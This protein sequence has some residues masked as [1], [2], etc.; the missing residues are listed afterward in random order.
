MSSLTF[1]YFPFFLC[2][3]HFFLLPFLWCLCSFVSYHIANLKKCCVSILVIGYLNLCQACTNEGIIG[4]KI[5]FNK[6]D[7]EYTLITEGL[8]LYTYTITWT[9]NSG[10]TL[11]RIHLNEKKKKKKRGGGNENFCRIILVVL[12][13][14]GIIKGVP[15]SVKKP[16]WISLHRTLIFISVP[17]IASMCSV[18]Y[19]KNGMPKTCLPVCRV[20]RLWLSHPAM[21]EKPQIQYSNQTWHYDI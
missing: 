3:L 13:G 10:N 5:S 21:Q 7:L 19:L 6:E 2:L 8:K 14:Y 20:L 9:N 17:A 4:N 12:T 18:L 11:F 1:K 15:V 16:H